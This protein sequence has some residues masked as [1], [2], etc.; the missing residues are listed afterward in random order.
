M[1]YLHDRYALDG[2]D[3]NT[4]TNILWCFGLHDRPW[5]ERPVFGKVR[6]MSYEGMKRKTDVNAYLK[7]IEYVARDRQG[8]GAAVIVAI[9]GASGFIGRRLIERLR[10]A[11][12]SVRTLGPLA[13]MPIITGMRFVPPPRRLPSTARMR[14]YTW[15]ASP[16]RNA[17]TRRS[18]A[19]S[20]RA[21]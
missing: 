8:P 12:H 9:T 5:F 16:S 15:Q 13:V 4:Y 11:G 2:R 7:E 10:A 21:A 1:I 6:Y 20:S 14:W 18:N 19:E 3:P 17:G